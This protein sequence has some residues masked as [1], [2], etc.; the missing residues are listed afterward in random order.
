M[1]HSVET[2]LLEDVNKTCVVSSD[3]MVKTT[4]KLHVI[5]YF[6]V[7]LIHMFQIYKF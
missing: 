1:Q 2:F 6:T 3:T 5:H 4:L 7:Y